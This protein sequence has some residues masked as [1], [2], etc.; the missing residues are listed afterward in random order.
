[1]FDL[2]EQIANKYVTTC[3]LCT[4]EDWLVSPT[5]A[6]KIDSG[7]VEISLR[8][9]VPSVPESFNAEFCSGA[10]VRS[11]EGSARVY[12]VL[13]VLEGSRKS[14]SGSVSKSER[15]TRTQEK[16]VRRKKEV[17]RRK[18]KRGRTAKLTP[19]VVSNHYAK[20][21]SFC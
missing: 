10:T 7:V 15:S 2:V 12:T 20:Y 19:S 17:E 16:E 4:F 11:S 18:K 5:R 8:D 13:Q 3:K 1:M 21:N 9:E 14:V 6:A